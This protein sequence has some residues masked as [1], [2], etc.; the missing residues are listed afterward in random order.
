MT[1]SWTY[2]LNKNAGMAGVNKK[3]ET[4]WKQQQLN[5]AATTM[6]SSKIRRHGSD[7][8]GDARY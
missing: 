1:T 3:P 5:A 6:A 4:P 2:L 7:A 8:G